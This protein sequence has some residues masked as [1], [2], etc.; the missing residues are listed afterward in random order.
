[1][2]G[3]LRRISLGLIFIYIVIRINIYPLMVSGWSS[4]RNYA[5]IGS[6][7]GVAQTVSYE[8]RFALIIMFFLIPGGSARL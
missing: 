4:N 7:R 1:M 5:R 6:L 2:G 3:F 8:V